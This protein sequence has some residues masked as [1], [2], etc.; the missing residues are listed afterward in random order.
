MSASRDISMYL[1]RP[2]GSRREGS[3]ARPV[4][5]PAPQSEAALS[6]S[7]LLRHAARTPAGL[8]IDL[9]LAPEAVEIWTQS[10]HDLDGVLAR[11]PFAQLALLWHVRIWLPLSCRHSRRPLAGAFAYRQASSASLRQ[12]AGS[13]PCLQLT[14]RC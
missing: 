3:A 10:L 11:A 4:V 8:K 7:C 14:T 5:V 2:D 13:G 6:R 1:L 9:P 12:S